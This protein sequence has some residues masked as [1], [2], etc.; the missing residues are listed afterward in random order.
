MVKKRIVIFL[1]LSLFVF[2][3]SGCTKEVKDKETTISFQGVDYTGLYTGIFENGLPQGN[4]EFN[5]NKESQYLN[6]KGSFAE[7]NLSAQGILETNLYKFKFADVER[8]GEYKGDLVDGIPNGYG[9]FTTQNSQKIEYTYEGEWKDGLFDG[10]GTTKW[11][12]PEAESQIGTY[13]QGKYVPE[14]YEMLS[15]LSGRPSMPFTLPDISY[16]FLKQHQDL[17]AVNTYDAIAPYLDGTIEYKHLQKTPGKYGDK[18]ISVNSKIQQIFEN[19][20]DDDWSK[21]SYTSLLVSD[22]DYNYY[23]VYYPGTC[24]YFEGDRVCVYG[25]PIGS[26]GFDNIGG[27]TTLVQVLAGSALL[28]I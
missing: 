23:W 3:C 17:F 22:G 20:V 19:V 4:G 5:Y 7:G 6:Y 16:N 28:P 12:D 21:Y 2:L 14:F 9:T 24:E 18:I 25:L 13:K 10:Q 15:N 1:I 26:S 27:G 11:D 8:I